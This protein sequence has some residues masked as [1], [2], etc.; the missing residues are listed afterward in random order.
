LTERSIRRSEIVGWSRPPIA[1]LAI[2]ER[3]KPRISA[4]QGKGMV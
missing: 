2:T 1:E 3:W 4:G